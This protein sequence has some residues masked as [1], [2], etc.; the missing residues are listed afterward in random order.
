MSSEVYNNGKDKLIFQDALKI[1]EE[2]YEVYDRAERILGNGYMNCTDDDNLKGYIDKEAIEEL[3]EDL[4][5]EIDSLNEKIEELEDPPINN[6][7][8]PEEEYD[9]EQ[10][11]EWKYGE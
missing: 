1:T 7:E 5:I 2:N 6:L 3:I 10:Y 11:Y 8:Y 9:R 4:C